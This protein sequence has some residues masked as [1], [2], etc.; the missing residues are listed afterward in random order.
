[1]VKDFLQA[2]RLY[3]EI[4]QIL[5]KV[6]DNE[7]E[8]GEGYINMF[9][10][11]VNKLERLLNRIDTDELNISPELR[12]SIENEY[13]TM[14]EDIPAFKWQYKYWLYR[15]PLL[16]KAN[17]VTGIIN[18]AIKK[19]YGKRNLVS[20]PE[21]KTKDIEIF[22]DSLLSRDMLDIYESDIRRII[23]GSYTEPGLYR[24]YNSY[25]KS[26]NKNT[27]FIKSNNIVKNNINKSINLIEKYNFKLISYDEYSL[28]FVP[29]VKQLN[30]WQ[31]ISTTSQFPEL[32]EIINTT[33]K[34]IHRKIGDG[35]KLRYLYNNTLNYLCIIIDPKG[36]YNPNKNV[37]IWFIDLNE[38]I[39]EQ[40]N[41]FEKND[42]T[43]DSLNE[44]IE[45]KKPSNIVED[46][47]SYK[48][49]IDDLKPYKNK[50]MIDDED[51]LPTSES[52][53]LYKVID[54]YFNNE[55]Y[56]NV[57]DEYKD[58]EPFKSFIKRMETNSGC[59]VL[60]LGI[61]N[62]KEFGN[63]LQLALYEFYTS[64]SYNYYIAIQIIDKLNTPGNIN[65]GFENPFVNNEDNNNEDTK[66]INSIP[67]KKDNLIKGVE[68][69]N[70]HRRLNQIKCL[71][72]KVIANT[73]FFKGDIVEAAP[74]VLLSHEDLYTKN[75]RDIVFDI[76]P[77][78][79]GIPLGYSS[80]Y[81]TS[82]ET[83]N[84]PNIDYMYDIE[85]NELIFITTKNIEKGE[86]LIIA[87]DDIVYDNQLT[88]ESFVDMFSPSTYSPTENGIVGIKAISQPNDPFNPG[89]SGIAPTSGGM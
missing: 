88:E 69:W 2:R 15:T 25:K 64:D 17:W 80:K 19:D 87:V 10:S 3:K 36:E 83:R 44:S 41:D 61:F 6:I 58:V 78:K 74:V 34:L 21:L 73:K 38:D 60:E 62:S 77:G 66:M 65:E 32:R 70:N 71:R 12:K 51:Q 28:V 1:M 48:K 33:Y 75:I 8:D 24:L 81:R 79:F 52:T 56:V 37:F 27:S 89:N 35:I 18:S 59:V 46:N 47:L 13:R 4:N 29:T 31:T 72:D 85:N 84:E 16:K 50:I 11:L 63:K 67:V 53:K 40:I 76:S 42:L 49:I 82:A 23:R 14:V 20:P 39:D 7:I 26:N 57:L 45:F 55:Y 22:L 86:E 54:K 5:F 9:N 68:L 30:E 43:I